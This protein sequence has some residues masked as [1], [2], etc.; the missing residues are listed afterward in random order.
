MLTKFQKTPTTRQDSFHDEL[1]DSNN[2][3]F[4]QRKMDGIL[5]IDK[6]LF[7]F[8]N[9]TLTQRNVD[10]EMDILDEVEKQNLE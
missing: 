3:K 8:L 6:K 5:E 10:L 7:D 1:I 2:L 4:R 9:D